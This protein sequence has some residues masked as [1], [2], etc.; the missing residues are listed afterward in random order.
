MKE[1]GI[2]EPSLIATHIIQE[3]EKS[4]NPVQL[5]SH[6]VEKAFDKVSHTVIKQALEAFGIPHILVQAV[7]QLALVGYAQVEVNGQRSG[8]FT[9]KI[10]S[11]QGDPLSSILFL[12]STEPLNLVLTTNFS[13]L[14]HKTRQGLLIPPLLY[15][16]DNNTAFNLKEAD[17]IIPVQNLYKEYSAVSGLNVNVKNLWLSA[18]TL[19]KQFRTVSTT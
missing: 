1:K 6:D 5:I 14:F 16:D 3:A 12:I 11:G 19:L 10:G 15:A 18:S 8:T 4:G 17:D 7:T 9:I 2:Q 13:H